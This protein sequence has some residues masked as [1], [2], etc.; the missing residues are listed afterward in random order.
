MAYTLSISNPRSNPAPTV[1]KSA[2]S[3]KLN[4]ILRFDQSGCLL[5]RRG[6]A[7][8]A[9]STY[10]QMPRYRRQARR[11]RLSF[12]ILGCRVVRFMARR[13][14]TQFTPVQPLSRHSPLTFT[15]ARHQTASKFGTEGQS[16]ARK[17]PD[18]PILDRGLECLTTRLTQQYSSCQRKRVFIFPI[19]F[20]GRDLYRCRRQALFNPHG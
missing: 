4:K 9:L 1:Q 19:P 17:V 10:R 8:A 18:S 3:L 15:R 5:E 14:T 16:M 11:E 6:G 13:A 20:D 2:K 7:E 12:F